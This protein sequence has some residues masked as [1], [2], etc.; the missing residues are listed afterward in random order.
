MNA[1]D[2]LI[3]S[4]NVSVRES[5]AKNSDKTPEQIKQLFYDYEQSVIDMLIEHTAFSYLIDYIRFSTGHVRQRA[6]AH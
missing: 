4:F 3:M 2:E 1:V 6:T 5:A